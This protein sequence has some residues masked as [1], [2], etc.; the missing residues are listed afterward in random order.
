MGQDART[1]FST[2]FSA[3]RARYS[4]LKQII[5]V[6][7]G[8]CFDTRETSMGAKEEN[9]E[10]KEPVL[11]EQHEAEKARVAGHDLRWWDV[12]NNPCQSIFIDID[13]ISFPFA[14]LIRWIPS[15]AAVALLP[16]LGANPHPTKTKGKHWASPF[17]LDEINHDSEGRR[18][19]THALRCSF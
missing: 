18:E 16:A 5:C 1:T 3:Q 4:M 14:Y 12:T 13:I 9:C 19:F 10:K 17:N 6:R 7:W 8:W 15:D 2:M 11:K